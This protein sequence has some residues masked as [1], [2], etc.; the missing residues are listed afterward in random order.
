MKYHVRITFKTNKK[1]EV[2]TYVFVMI[3]KTLQCNGYL[4]E[5]QFT[6]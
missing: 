4:F 2:L 3:A 1:A 6:Q 5:F